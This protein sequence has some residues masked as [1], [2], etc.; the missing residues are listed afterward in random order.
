MLTQWLVYGHC[1]D[2]YREFFLNSAGDLATENDIPCF[3]LPV[4]N[5]IIQIGTAIRM[6][7]S[8]YTL[9]LRD[10]GNAIEFPSWHSVPVS[11]PRS[12]EFVNHPLS[13]FDAQSWECPMPSYDKFPRSSVS[14]R[15]AA[16]PL[17]SPTLSQPLHTIV[18]ESLYRPILA[19]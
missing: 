11:S 18:F 13:A 10:L 1:S 5:H 3:L 2:P 17:S 14:N 8:S 4:R 12:K 9:G 19:R 16:S 15:P 7:P 6:L